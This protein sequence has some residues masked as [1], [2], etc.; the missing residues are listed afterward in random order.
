M[1]NIPDEVVNKT[2]VKI[3]QGIAIVGVFVGFVS[4]GA[5]SNDEPMA[6]VVSAL[7]ALGLF[8]VASMVKTRKRLVGG[9][10]RYR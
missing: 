7:I 8:W 2:A 3:Q 9:S 10:A 6:G 4:F 5:F 1:A